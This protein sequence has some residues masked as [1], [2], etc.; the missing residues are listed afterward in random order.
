MRR[1]ESFFVNKVYCEPLIL[2]VLCLFVATNVRADD[3]YR[4]WLRYDQLPPQVVNSYRARIKS[5][6]VEGESATF[7]AIRHELTQG[8][9]GLLGTPIAVAKTGDASVVV[10]KLQDDAELKKLGPEGFRIR[11]IR[12]GNR[13]VIAIAS[14]TDIG[15]L[16]GAFHF[17]RL[18]HTAQ[19]I[20]RLQIDQKPAL[21]LRLLNHLVGTRQQCRRDG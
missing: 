1:F 14:T 15:A 19:P 4:L 9:A 8:C 11:M 12:E 18:L 20:D 17:L 13:D 2:C 16:Y 7:D 10:R 6:T 21:K 3:G 5:I